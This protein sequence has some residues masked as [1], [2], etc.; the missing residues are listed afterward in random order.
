MSRSLF[1]LAL[2]AIAACS[3]PESAGSDRVGPEYAVGGGEWNTGGGITAVTRV[4]ERDGATIVCGAWATDRQTMLSMDLNDDV[5]ATGSVY[6]GGTRLVQN[7]SFMRRAPDVAALAGA[8]AH[9]VTVSKPW[10]AEFAEAAPRLR[11]PR[12][13]KIDDP[14]M[15]DPI[16]FRE[17]SRAD[18]LH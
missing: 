3:R 10:R 17:A 9:C 8:Q 6:L 1:V 18:V 2:L 11:F 14:L 15:G 4:F 7:L 16:I 5:M 13:V 12:Y